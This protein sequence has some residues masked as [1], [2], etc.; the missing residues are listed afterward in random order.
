MSARRRPPRRHNLTEA[1]TTNTKSASPARY[2]IAFQ[3]FGTPSTA[4]KVA[5]PKVCTVR[6]PVIVR[7]V[8]SDPGSTSAISPI[9]NKIGV[10]SASHWRPVPRYTQMNAAREAKTAPI[11]KSIQGSSAAASPMECTRMRASSIPENAAMVKALE[12]NTSRAGE[13]CARPMRNSINPKVM[14]A[15]ATMG[16][17]TVIQFMTRYRWLRVLGLPQARGDVATCPHL[18]FYAS[19]RLLDLGPWGILRVP[20]RHRCAGRS[21]LPPRDRP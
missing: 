4:L 19:I 20:L 2:A 3:G 1:S 7:Y 16:Q 6:T 9:A 18:R 21:R 14:M 5:P 13:R 8:M 15:A 10:A 11:A 17:E 12:E